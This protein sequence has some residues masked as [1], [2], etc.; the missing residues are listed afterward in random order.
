M[1]ALVVAM[2][3]SLMWVAGIMVLVAVLLEQLLTLVLNYR[4]SRDTR[5]EF[6]VQVWMHKI[7]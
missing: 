5:H 7:I 2:A 1:A 4:F 6:G 3:C